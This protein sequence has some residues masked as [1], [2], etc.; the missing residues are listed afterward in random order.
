M[1]ST[2]LIIY[3]F[4]DTIRY[5]SWGTRCNSFFDLDKRIKTKNYVHYIGVFFLLNLWKLLST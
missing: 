3:G 1:D 4:I 5:V 2:R